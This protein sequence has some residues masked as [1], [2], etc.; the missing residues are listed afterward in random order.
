MGGTWAGR[1][2][3]SALLAKLN[4]IE[5]LSVREE[6][7]AVQLCSNVRTIARR[8]DIIQVGMKPTKIH[9]I[10]EG[11]AARYSV[12]K[13]GS[14]RITAFLLPGDFCDIHGTVLAAMDHS[15]STLTDCRVGFIEPAEM[16][17]ITRS[18]PVLTR[19][20]WR[21]TLVDEA[22]LRR[23]LV[24]AGRSDAK[25]AIA[26]LLCE[27]HARLQLIGLTNEGS[28]ALPVTQEEIGDATGLTSVHVNRMLGGLRG[29]GLI[30]LERDQLQISDIAALRRA[31]GFDPNYLHLA[32]A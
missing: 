27:L 3:H 30:E 26:H 23:W 1:L 12:L 17:E 11:W 20:F 32:S 16:N 8:Q 9:V 29:R 18:T 28:F 19:A 31:S 15:I 25:E 24:T 7:A 21:S 5:K 6:Q 13:N 14:R 22:I 2:V 4:A 10:L